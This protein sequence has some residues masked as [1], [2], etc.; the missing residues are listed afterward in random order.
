MVVIRFA[1]VTEETGAEAVWDSAF[2]LDRN[3]FS[4]RVIRLSEVLSR[5][6]R[7]IRRVFLVTFLPGDRR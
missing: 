6:E 3:I 4:S 1:A 7:A 2:T 5:I